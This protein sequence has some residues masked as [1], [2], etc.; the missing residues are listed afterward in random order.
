[1]DLIQSVFSAYWEHARIFA[2]GHL[3]ISFLVLKSLF[4]FAR[5]KFDDEPAP[6]IW[7]QFEIRSNYIRGLIGLFLLVGIAGTFL[8]LWEVASSFGNAGAA[9]QSASS[10]ALG[11]AARA[12]ETIQLLFRGI[13]KAFPVG[14]I[15]LLLTLFGNLIAD[16]IESSKRKKIE[17]FMDVFADPVLTKLTQV[18]EPVANFGATLHLSLEPVIEKLAS[19]LQPIPIMMAQQRDELSNAK[20]ALVEAASALRESGAQISASVVGLKEMAETSRAALKSATTLSSNINDYF[21]KITS[22]LDLATDHASTAFEK[23]DTALTY[24]SASVTG[25]A[26]AMQ[27]VPADLRADLT[28]ALVASYN[29]ASEAREQELKDLYS[30]ARHQFQINMVNAMSTVTSDFERLKKDF[31]GVAVRV[32]TSVANAQNSF[33]RY[34]TAWRE[35]AQTLREQIVKEIDPQFR[36]ELETAAK[37]AKEAVD[38]A[39]RAGHE[40]A[41]ATKTTS[42]DLNRLYRDSA[43]K[44]SSSA[45]LLASTLA[46]MTDRIELSAAKLEKTTLASARPPGVIRRASSAVVD[47]LRRPI[48]AFWRRKGSQPKKKR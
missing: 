33:E 41:S 45:K 6:T 48:G 13:A 47:T 4:S 8:G 12:N 42:A 21:A 27:R 31:E 24:M 35:E 36:S 40:F 15:G 37:S 17:A 32:D 29:E 30:E 9:A 28:A 38:E 46:S 34:D 7:Q 10:G 26:A 3:F 23:Y 25:A 11:A 1:M 18:L 39:A 43:E 22:K 14:F 19:T 16:W 2:V 44:L 20:T 5:W